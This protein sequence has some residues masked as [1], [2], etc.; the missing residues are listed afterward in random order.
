MSVQETYDGQPRE[1]AVLLHQGLSKLSRQI[2]N[3]SLPP[4]IT[5]ERLSTLAAIEAHGPISVTALAEM[6]RVRPATMSRMISALVEDGLVR[7]QEDKEDKRGVLVSSTRK[8]RR[9]YQRANQQYLKQLGAALTQ[10]ERD[11]L[12]AMR[13]LADALEKLTSALDR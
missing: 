1:I 6:E 4:G 5:P 2:R 7:R 12:A 10:L 8:G 11:Q 9:A 13:A 3:I